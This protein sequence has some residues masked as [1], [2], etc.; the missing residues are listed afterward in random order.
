MLSHLSHAVSSLLG[1]STALMVCHLSHALRA[2]SFVGKPG[3]LD[4]T[5]KSL[6]SKLDF[7]SKMTLR[8]S[9]YTLY[10][11]FQCGEDTF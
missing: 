4:H 3:I 11:L 8:Q 2:L 9:T 7:F 10:W 5:C 1:P 6:G